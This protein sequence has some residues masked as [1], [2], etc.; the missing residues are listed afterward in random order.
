MKIKLDFVTNSSSTCYIFESF[1]TIKKL[2]LSSKFFD[3]WD[4]FRCFSTKKHLITFT[5]NEKCDWIDEAR[6]SPR[7]Y[8]QIGEYTFESLMKI[9]LNGKKAIMIYVDR[10]RIYKMED[11]LFIEMEKLGAVFLEKESY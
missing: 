9:V 3:K 7:S 4:N 5:Q 10:D 11:Q 1:N 6:C 2:D 8:D